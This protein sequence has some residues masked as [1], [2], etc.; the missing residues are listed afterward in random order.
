MY[1]QKFLFLNY[2]SILN[3]LFLFVFLVLQILIILLYILPHRLYFHFLLFLKLIP[4]ILFFQKNT[5]IL[6]LCLLHFHHQL[7][8]IYQM[9]LKYYHYSTYL[10]LLYL[11]IQ[12]FQLNFLQNFYYVFQYFQFSI[13]VL[14]RLQ[15]QDFYC[16][17]FFNIFVSRQI[18]YFI[19]W[20]CY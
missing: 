16:N 2:H 3:I 5:Q 20:D 11:N 9:D 15:L 1:W 17:R 8:V 13:L 18:C 7:L 10:F 4:H 19:F 14:Q 12:N 6:L